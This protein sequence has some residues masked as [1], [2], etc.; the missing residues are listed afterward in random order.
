[1]LNEIVNDTYN[2][3]KEV[4]DITMEYQNMEDKTEANKESLKVLLK[5]EI[6]SE[7]SAQKLNE[8]GKLKINNIEDVLKKYKEALKL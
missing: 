7:K 3:I 4:Y 5:Y 8:S 1:M 6:V 2:S